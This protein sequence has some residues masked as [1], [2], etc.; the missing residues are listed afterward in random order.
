MGVGGG[1][2]GAG[3]GGSSRPHSADFNYIS[4][5][6]S[7]KGIRRRLPIFAGDGTPS[8]APT[9]DSRSLVVATPQRAHSAGKYNLGWD[10]RVKKRARQEILSQSDFVFPFCF[11]FCHIA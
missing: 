4:H 7:E 10:R 11:F 3:G 9:R 6:L 2:G 8:R 1:G 5:G